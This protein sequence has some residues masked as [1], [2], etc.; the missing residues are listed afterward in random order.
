MC[1]LEVPGGLSLVM[2][3]SLQHIGAAVHRQRP[4]APQPQ[5]ERVRRWLQLEDLA[6]THAVGPADV[7]RMV[8]LEDTGFSAFVWVERA[9]VDWV[10]V[11][12]GKLVRRTSLGTACFIVLRDHIKNVRPL[13]RARRCA[14]EGIP[15]AAVVLVELTTE[16]HRPGE[17]IMP[18]VPNNMRRP[19]QAAAMCAALRGNAAALLSSEGSEDNANSE[20]VQQP[21]SGVPS[22]SPLW[23]LGMVLGH[24]GA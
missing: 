16:P 22:N 14:P 19:Q 13:C 15:P 20:G 23:V 9:S 8:V 12:A 11:T 17:D 18:V 24:R 4:Y 6:P 21:A 5:E 1:L 3:V 2:L 10:E 7:G